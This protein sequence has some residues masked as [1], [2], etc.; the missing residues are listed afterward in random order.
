V[1]WRALAF[2]LEVKAYDPYVSEEYMAGLGVERA[3]LEDVLRCD[4]V[5]LHCL[6]TDETR[7]IVDGDALRAM[8]PGA[9]LIN[10]AR[11]PCVDTA[12]LTE[13][14]AS[15][16]LAGAALDV[17]DPEPLPAGHPLLALPNV[18]VTPHAAFLSRTS[19]LEA[20]QKTCLEVVRALRGETPHH[21]CNPEVLEA[22]SCRFV[23][24]AERRGTDSEPAG[25]RT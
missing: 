20:R 15:G 23:S 25:E 24:F 4:Y 9:F 5:S 14:L 6:L 16:R 8:K 21:V 13:A 10:T 1:A 2:G 12:A 17:L 7:H 3:G 22:T 11:G 18:I 19:L